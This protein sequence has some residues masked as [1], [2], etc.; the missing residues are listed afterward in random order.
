MRNL[1]AKLS[2]GDV[3]AIESKYHNKC[4]VKLY[5]RLRDLRNTES[6]ADKTESLVLGI[7]LS[8]IITYVR[9]CK[10]ASESSPVFK[11]SDIKLYSERIH[12]T[13]LKEQLLKHI[14]GL[15]AIKQGRDV[16]L[17]FEEDN[18]DALLDACIRSSQDDGI[19]LAKGAEIV[20][21]DIFSKF[22][23]FDGSF[24]AE[25]I[26]SSV[27]LS[28][29]YLIQMMLEGT[30][31]SPDDEVLED[32]N[33]V[34]HEIAQL[35]RYNASKQIRHGKSERHQLERETP[36]P[37]YLGMM[38]HAKTRKPSITDKLAKLGLSISSDRVDNLKSKLTASLCKK[39]GDHDLVC[40]PCLQEGLFT[41]A[42]VDNI[43]HNATSTT[44][45][46]HFHGT[47]ISVFQHPEQA[48]QRNAAQYDFTTRD[49]GSACLELPEYY[50]DI[51]P[52]AK[53]KCNRPVTVTSSATPLTVSHTPIKE[54]SNWLK[55]IELFSEKGQSFDISVQISWSAFNEK[56]LKTNPRP[57]CLSALMP[58]INENINSLA[59]VKHT[60][61][62]IWKA[63]NQVNAGQTPV[64]T[65]D[66]PVKSC[67]KIE[68]C[69]PSFAGSIACAYEKAF[70]KEIE[71]G[72]TMNY[73]EWMIGKRETSV[74]FEYWNT[75]FEL[76]ALLL[77]LVKSIRLADCAMYV[78][79][80]E[81]IIPWIFALDHVH[82]SRWLPVFV[83]D[84]KD[85][86]TRHKEV[87]QQF[88]KG[89]FTIQKTNRKF[90]CISVDQAH[91]QNN[92][93]IK[94]EGGAI[95][96]LE[97]PM[98]L[99]KWMDDPESRSHHENTVAF[100]KKFR[101][102]VAALVK[103]FEKEGNPFEEE[104]DTL[105]MIVSKSVMDKKAAISVR[106]ARKIGEDQY[107]DFVKER[108]ATTEKLIHNVIKRNKLPLFRQ[109]NSVV[110]A[111]RKLQITSLKQ[112]CNLYA[113]LCIACQTRECDLD[114][115][116]SMRI[117][118]PYFEEPSVT[119]LVIDGAALVQMIEPRDSAT[120]GDYIRREFTSQLLS[121]V[122]SSS[123]TRMDVVF[124]VYRDKSIKSSA[125]E[126]RGTGAGIRVLENTPI[127]R[128]WRN[129]LRVNENKAELFRLIAKI[130]A[131]EDTLR[132]TQV[133]FATDDYVTTNGEAI[134]NQQI[135]PNNHE[136]ADTR[137]FVHVKN[138]SSSGHQNVTI[139]TDVVVIATSLFPE[140]GLVQLWIEFGTGKDKRW[141]PI[142]DYANALGEN[143]CAG[144]LFWYA[145]CGSD[146]VSSFSV[147]GKI[148][149][150]DTWKALPEITDVFVGL[151]NNPNKIKM[152]EM[153]LL[154][155]YVVLLYDRSSHCLTV[156]D[157][158]RWL[159]TKKSR[160]VEGLPPT[161]DAL[162]QHAR[163]AALQ[164]G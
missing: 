4:L 11:L 102:D 153:L 82:Y 59:M 148:T 69:A 91:E 161:E 48:A 109:K 116:F 75:V 83:Q 51:S 118:H 73:E 39:Y 19:S 141:L 38:L 12:S 119:A 134:D 74:Q 45:Q 157:A 70:N 132:N 20:R 77:L 2:Q 79:A 5:N 49:S 146:T 54:S 162:L 135:S 60:M 87:H 8:D 92:K 14:P 90:S 10:E 147:R 71:D 86:P 72:K 13:R 65:A 96:I 64:I 22:P 47:G 100:E 125:R 3:V 33:T 139:K 37:I 126:K 97:R 16:L 120:F 145:F 62:I 41:T 127:T 136:E 80:L 94:D 15:Q 128:K 1:L 85:L 50:T 66:Q 101:K 30:N 108:L 17:S 40:P 138:L 107:K 130:C 29:V 124:D 35:I 158:R 105:M 23:L 155:R 34:A 160:T 143:I 84:L 154:Q 25:Y 152:D 106:N 159:F 32:T 36:L 112:D 140:I 31:I 104:S 53:R 93:I 26:K 142:H 42:A 149:T 44:A 163:R 133:V 129:F 88:S 144:L 111:K 115:F 24:N 137:I 67:K 7:A 156:N 89:K 43:D 18:G 52:V 46:Q 21:K 63:V 103:A 110:S 122:K 81:Q 58:L 78:D 150:W 9:K 6:Q 114:E 68:V 99:M 95:G 28:L 27:P 131:A 123:I 151:S 61:Q 56:N 117:I 57:K 113:S 164:G 98:V 76:E 55:Q 121:R